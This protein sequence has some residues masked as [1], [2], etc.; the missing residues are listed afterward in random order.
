MPLPAASRHAQGPPAAWQRTLTG[1]VAW[2]GREPAASVRASQTCRASAHQSAVPGLPAGL[3][4]KACVSSDTVPVGGTGASQSRKVEISR[5]SRNARHRVCWC[6]SQVVR[7]AFGAASAGRPAASQGRRHGEGAGGVLGLR[8]HKRLV[9]PHYDSRRRA[10]SCWRRRGRR[11]TGVRAFGAKLA[12]VCARKGLCFVFEAGTECFRGRI[13][14]PDS[15]NGGK[16]KVPRGKSVAFSWPDPG[17]P[18]ARTGT[19]GPRHER[20]CTRT[21]ILG[22][23]LCRR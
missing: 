20:A 3:I 17:A 15:R 2:S 7:P 11:S 16:C 1:A 5:M 21:G 23:W 18:R 13:A 14:K 10:G 12:Q 8:Q 19:A 22:E 4:H 6:A 9:G